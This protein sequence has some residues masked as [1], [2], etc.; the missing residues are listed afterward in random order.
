MRLF[1]RTRNKSAFTNDKL[2]LVPI[3]LSKT[4]FDGV[5]ELTVGFKSVGGMITSLT[6]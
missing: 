4:M 6:K 5:L 3:K 2:P 1:F